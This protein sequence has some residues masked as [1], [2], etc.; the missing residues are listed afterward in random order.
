[1]KNS[2]RKSDDFSFC[3]GILELELVFDSRA[4]EIFSLFLP[5][6]SS[7]TNYLDDYLE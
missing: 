6:Q 4:R 7:L 2:L 3:K 5:S 1:M